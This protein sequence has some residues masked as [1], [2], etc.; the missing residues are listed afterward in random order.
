M[1]PPND[2]SWPIVHKDADEWIDLTK[3]RV[4]LLET[5][6]HYELLGDWEG[7]AWGWAFSQN[8]TFVHWGNAYH[9]GQLPLPPPYNKP[10]RCRTAS[11]SSIPKEWR[12]GPP[13]QP[14]PETMEQRVARLEAQMKEVSKV[15]GKGGAE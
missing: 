9:R 15:S 14:E 7:S 2:P 12:G 13:K 8:R 3:T 1:I 5:D 11:T 6:M 10:T 4:E